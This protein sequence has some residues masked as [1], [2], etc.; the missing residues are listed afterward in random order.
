VKFW[1]A[2]EGSSFLYVISNPPHPCSLRED[3]LKRGCVC[4][5]VAQSFLIMMTDVSRR[6]RAIPDR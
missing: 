5:S 3:M 1:E 2:I 6:Y 4:E